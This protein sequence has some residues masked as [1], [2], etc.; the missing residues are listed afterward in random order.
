[1][2]LRV[3]VG[4]DHP[5]TAVGLGHHSITVTTAD[6]VSVGCLLVAIVI[7]RRVLNVVVL[8]YLWVRWL[9]WL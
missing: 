5:A 1:M 4:P 7:V 8:R 2:A 6:G 3:G 9:W